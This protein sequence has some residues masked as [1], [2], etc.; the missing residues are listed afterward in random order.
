[1]GYNTKNYR[2]QGGE[3]TVIGGEVIL[4]ADCIIT[5]E[6]PCPIPYVPASTASTAANAVKDL[7]VLIENLKTAGLVEP[8]VPTLQ[9]TILETEVAVLV[10]EA[11]ILAADAQVSDGRAL[12]YQWFSNTGA[13]NTGGT[14]ISGANQSTYEAPTASTGTAYYYCVVSDATAGAT[15]AF[16]DAATEACTV[17]VTEA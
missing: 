5:D 14:A 1:M 15:K 3:K 12:A 4:A 9:A 8:E 11:L 17:T 2:E 7:N 13:T 10:G 6:R 16:A